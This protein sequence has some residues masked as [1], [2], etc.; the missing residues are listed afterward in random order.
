[1]TKHDHILCSLLMLSRIDQIGPLF[2]G[3]NIRMK[4]TFSYEVLNILIHVNFRQTLEF[5]L[6]AITFFTLFISEN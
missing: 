5:Y 4:H 2:S 3:V 6:F 1:M